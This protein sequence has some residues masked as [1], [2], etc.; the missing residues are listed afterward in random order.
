MYVVG[1]E[2]CRDGQGKPDSRHVTKK[3]GSMLFIVNT[4]VDESFS[5]MCEK[6]KSTDTKIDYHLD[7]GDQEL[8]L[9][10]KCNNCGN[11]VEATHCG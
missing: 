8:I 11:E 1:K 9:Y 4:E 5:L 10:F 2:G 6:C 3:E 7:W